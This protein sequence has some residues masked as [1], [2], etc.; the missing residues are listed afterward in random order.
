MIEKRLHQVLFLVGYGLNP[1]VIYFVT[2]PYLYFWQVLPSVAVG[3][4]LMRTKPLS[5]W[6]ATF[7]ASLCGTALVTRPTVIFCVLLFFGLLLLNRVRTIVA[8]AAV[9]SFGA[10]VL[11]FWQP[12]TH[13]TVWHTAYIGVGAYPNPYMKG[14]TDNNAFDL[15][16]EKTGQKLY[17]YPG[18]NY[19]DSITFAKNVAIL[20]K[21]YFDVVKH[22]PSL[23]LRN[24]TL[25][26][27][28][29]FSIGYLV[30][31]SLA[32]NYGT[33]FMGFAIF[34]TLLFYK[35]FLWVIAIVF[36]SLSF[37]PYFPP[38]PAYMFGSYLLIALALIKTIIKIFDSRR[39]TKDRMTFG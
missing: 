19:F 32:L 15:F 7:L 29:S 18:G 3:F 33:A 25:N 8:L 5:L 30:D 2:F 11:F 6:Q 34:C 10:V 39:K 12:S 20:R 36:S 17:V 13:K 21:A 35:Q 1:L 22:S 14:L 26:F 38:I 37:S 16:E 28:Q 23:V 24:A 27:F 31:Y 4:V 9:L